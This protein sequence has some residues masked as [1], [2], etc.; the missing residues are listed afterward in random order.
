VYLSVGLRE[1]RVDIGELK[2][3]AAIASTHWILE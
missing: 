2:D 3:G 1:L